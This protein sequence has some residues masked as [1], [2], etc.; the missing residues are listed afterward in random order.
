[1]S[2]WRT[3]R[4]N[5]ATPWTNKNDSCWSETR[6]Y[7]LVHNKKLWMIVLGIGT[8]Q[9]RIPFWP[10]RPRIFRITRGNL[11]H[12]LIFP[13]SLRI[14]KDFE[15]Q[16]TNTAVFAKIFIFQMWVLFAIWF[17]VKRKQVRIQESLWQNYKLVIFFY[18]F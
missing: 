13:H 17:I 15:T 4:D 1:M 7:I 5:A 2:Q 18:K 14:F 11:L 10:P 3:R 8:K 16:I 12:Y 6:W 9:E